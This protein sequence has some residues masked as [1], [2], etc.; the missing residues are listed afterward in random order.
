MSR[1]E[2]LK[3]KL[4]EII[5]IARREGELPSKAG[6]VIRGDVD[7]ILKICKENGLK[8]L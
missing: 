2:E 4:A 1:T 7:D 8:F 3:E 6:R 5:R